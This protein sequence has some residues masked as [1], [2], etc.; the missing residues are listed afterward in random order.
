MKKLILLLILFSFSIPLVFSAP[1]PQVNINQ[2]I[3][4]QIFYPQY[5]VVKQGE[6]FY[7]HIHV[8]NVTTGKEVNNTNVNCTL[9]L[10]NKTGG[11]ILENAQLTKDTDGR[12]LNYTVPGTV[13]TELGT[14]AFR[15]YCNTDGIGGE[16]AG[17]FIVTYS[18]KVITIQQMIYYIFIILSLMGLIPTL[19]YTYTR[20]PN[21]NPKDDYGQILSINHLKYLRIPIVG[22]VYWLLVGISFLISAIA[23]NYFDEVIMT[24]LFFSVYVMLMRFSIPFLI[25]IFGYLLIEIFRDKELNDLMKRGLPTRQNGL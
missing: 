2:N 1:P 12:D 22:M 11:H 8:A 18:G 23:R 3:G 4:I 15:I 25:L 16:V 5:E 21:D 24:N 9:D 20:L 17:I 7:L 6:P 13:F 10:Y 14:K 19:V